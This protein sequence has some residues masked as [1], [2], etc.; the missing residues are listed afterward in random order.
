MKT[1]KSLLVVIAVIVT[2]SISYAGKNTQVNI[3]PQEE[4]KMYVIVKNQEPCR[5]T[6]SVLNEK[7]DAVYYKWITKKTENYRKI[8]DFSKL[9]AGRYTIKLT[10][11]DTVVEKEIAVTDTRI[12]TTESSKMATL[13]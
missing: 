2:G 11:K 10:S 1:I 4:K 7:G 12:M 3:I 9:Q 6:I 13:K 8:F 5:F